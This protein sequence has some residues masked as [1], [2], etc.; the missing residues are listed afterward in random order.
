MLWSHYNIIIIVKK[1]N[2]GRKD[3]ENRQHSEKKMHER[4]KGKEGGKLSD[5]QREW[6][7]DLKDAL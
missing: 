6:V 1:K 5:H 2:K 4:N 7:S 3:K